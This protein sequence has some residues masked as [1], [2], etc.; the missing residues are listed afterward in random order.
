MN[1]IGLSGSLRR[2]SLNTRLLQAA[3]GQLPAG[4]HFHLLA[5][6]LPLY[7]EEHEGDALP[8]AVHAFR[9]AI[10]AADAVLI[11]SPEYNHSFSGVLKNALDWA[12]RPAFE[13]PMKGKPV[14]LLSASL[15]PLG[16]VRAQAQLRPVLA[17]MLAEV[18][19]GVEFSL[20]LAQQAFNAEGR[21]VDSTAQRRLQRFMHGFIAWARP[22]AGM[23]PA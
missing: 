1:I 21:L 14:A 3:A 7:S 2:E 8:D 10:A 16:G 17:S 9:Q 23:K 15:S 20:P 13:S 22:V 12:S 18:Y 5:T 11:A 19:P 4:S 6:D